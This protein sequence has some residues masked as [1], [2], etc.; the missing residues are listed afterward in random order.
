[1]KPR[2]SYVRPVIEAI[3]FCEN[4]FNMQYVRITRSTEG[5]HHVLDIMFL[6]G[7]RLQ[8]DL[9]QGSVISSESLIRELIDL[10]REYRP[11]SFEAVIPELNAVAK[12]ASRV[13]SDLNGKIELLSFD[14]NLIEENRVRARSSW[15]RT[16]L[17]NE[18]FGM[19]LYG[20]ISLEDADEVLKSH[21]STS[22][23][24]P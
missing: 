4:E 23:L 21:Y 19:Q 18:I 16:L 3:V 22:T 8:K 7:L 14:S 9:H 17:Y 11:N 10:A 24:T 15:R 12:A 5:D 1:M 20:K 6:F 2:P 13:L